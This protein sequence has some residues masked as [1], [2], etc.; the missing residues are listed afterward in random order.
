MPLFAF[1]ITVLYHPDFIEPGNTPRWIAL[2]LVL[3][4]LLLVNR[5]GPP[6]LAHWLGLLWLAWAAVTLLWAHSLYDGLIGLWQWILIAM[7]FYIGSNLSSRTIAWTAGA[8]ALGMGFNGFLALAQTV[9][10]F[11]YIQQ[12]VSPAGT[13]VNKNYLAEASLVGLVLALTIRHR[14]IRYGLAA[15][16][17]LGWLLPLSRGAIAAGACVTV[18]WL[19]SRD[20]TRRRLCR[21]SAAVLVTSF[22]LGFIW[23]FHGVD[24]RQSSFGDRVAFYAN[25][26]AMIADKPFGQGVGNFWASYPLYHDAMID[27]PSD[28]Y[29][30]DSRPRTA[31]NDMLTIFAETGIIGGLCLLIILFLVIHRSRSPYRY[32]LFAV[33]TLGAFNFPLFLPVTGFMAAL[34]AGHMLVHKNR[35]HSP[36]LGRWLRIVGRYGLERLIFNKKSREHQSGRRSRARLSVRAKSGSGLSS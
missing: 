35:N 9:F 7:A 34:F 31:H 11:D 5:H 19:I 2:S 14:S 8:I 33:L 28:A 32:A 17:A 16:C 13:F 30:F 24:L 1:L 36:A 10:G 4:A 26:I 18:L 12:T 23:H 27:T 6:T 20:R 29:R 3:P 21:T 15:C 25:S 22:A